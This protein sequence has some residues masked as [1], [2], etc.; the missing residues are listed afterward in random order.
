MRAI[1]II[2]K[3]TNGCNLQCSYCYN[4]FN[5]NAKILAPEVLERVISQAAASFDHVKFIWHGGEPLL[6]GLDFYKRAKALQEARARPGLT[7]RNNIQTN[8]TLVD[9]PWAEWCR[10]NGFG[11]GLSIDGPVG[12][13]GESRAAK[14]GNSFDAIIAGMEVIKSVMGG[15]GAICVVH[16]LNARRGRD[17]YDFFRRQ[18][19]DSVVLLPIMN[20]PKFPELDLCD[21]DYFAF[22]KDFFD[23]WIEDDDPI[24]EVVPFRQIVNALRGDQPTLCSYSGGCFRDFVS[25]EHDGAVYPCSAFYTE[26]YRLGNIL[27][28]DLADLLRSARLEAMRAEMRRSLQELC[29]DCR[30][31]GVCQGGCR[32]AVNTANNSIYGRDPQCEGRK[33]V[34]DYV[35]AKLKQQLGE[36]LARKARYPRPGER[37]WDLVFPTHGQPGPA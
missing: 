3:V 27:T 32:E 13:T 11:L 16:K 1:S 15:V 34:F 37:S 35:E 7:M 26:D 24:E 33:Q 36:T 29:S 21:A 22:H 10:D 23:A 25:I 17:V 6:A 2:V 14:R 8:G 28:D 9:R 30:Y 31:L 12:I 19:V 5:T 18:G 4:R 20:D